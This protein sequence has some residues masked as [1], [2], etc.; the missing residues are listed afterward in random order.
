VK[1]VLLSFENDKARDAFLS[2]VKKNA[3]DDPDVVT[4]LG[5]IRLDPPIM[6][7]HQVPA[8]VFVAGQKLYEG[9][10]TDMDKKFSQECASTT[11]AVEM[12]E[13]RN[14]EWVRV[15]RRAKATAVGRNPV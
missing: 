11:A 12:K 9:M 1:T 13:L 7:D 6:A 14:G 4:A 5:T 3:G 10:K 8:A 15:R 2:A